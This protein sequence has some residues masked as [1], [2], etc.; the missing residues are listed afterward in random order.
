[1]CYIL[2]TEMSLLINILSINNGMRKNQRYYPDEIEQVRFYS[3]ELKKKT[4]IF[5]GTGKHP[6]RFRRDDFVKTVF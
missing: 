3:C 4:F 1:M 5:C 2:F 6:R